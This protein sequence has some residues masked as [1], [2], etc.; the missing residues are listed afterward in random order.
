MH[1]IE[2]KKK[3][4][5]ESNKKPKLLYKKD[6]IGFEQLIYSLSYILSTFFIYFLV[7]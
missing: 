4:K 5:I 6:D 7:A 2:S 3:S 1:I